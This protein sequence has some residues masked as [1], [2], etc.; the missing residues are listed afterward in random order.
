MLCAVLYPGRVGEEGG[1]GDEAGQLGGQVAREGRPGEDQR[2]ARLRRT[3][4]KH[5]L[6]YNSK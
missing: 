4:H 1:G 5:K 3:R 6:E 2:G